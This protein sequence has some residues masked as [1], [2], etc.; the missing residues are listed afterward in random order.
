MHL[1][2]ALFCINCYA[3]VAFLIYLAVLMDY[4]VWIFTR[5]KAA[6]HDRNKFHLVLAY[7]LFFIHPWI[8][9][10]NILLRFA[11]PFTRHA[12]LEFSFPE[13]L[14]FFQ[15]YGNSDPRESV[16]NYSLCYHFL[17]NLVENVRDQLWQRYHLQGRGMGIRK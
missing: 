14:H 2:S 6:L 1:S 15:G 17:K 16:G 12:A 5:I 7:Y 8:Q 9:F 11:S 4:I 3:H 13:C 10:P